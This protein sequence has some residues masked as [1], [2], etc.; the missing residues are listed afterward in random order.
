MP[1][2]LTCILQTKVVQFLISNCIF[3]HPYYISSC[4]NKI[5]T[6]YILSKIFSFNLCQIISSKISIILY[7]FKHSN[8][9]SKATIT[10]SMRLMHIFMLNW[11]H[12]S[13]ILWFFS[14]KQHH[15]HISFHKTLTYVMFTGS[16]IDN[17]QQS[18]CLHSN[19]KFT[20]RINIHTVPTRLWL[21]LMIF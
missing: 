15:D 20:C 3:S 1:W 7:I 12:F 8:Q 19:Q 4:R 5:N 9:V 13:L 6:L 2:K 16:T 14:Q 10:I 17:G 21:Q 11:Q 18:T